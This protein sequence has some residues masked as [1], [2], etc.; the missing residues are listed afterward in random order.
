[1]N[2]LEIAAIIWAASA[3]FNIFSHLL[4]P[5]A[6]T[7]DYKTLSKE[8]A[9]LDLKWKPTIL[10]APLIAVLFGVLWGIVV[11]IYVENCIG[12]IAKKIW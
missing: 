3:V 12:W 4:L 8:I 9:E 2:L 1:M 6:F 5:F 10:A 7:R 11:W